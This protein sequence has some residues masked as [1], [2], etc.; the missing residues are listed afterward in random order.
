MRAE[1]DSFKQVIDRKDQELAWYRGRV[2]RLEEQLRGIVDPEL[3]QKQI[4][5][6]VN[7]QS[8]FGLADFQEQHPV[9]AEESKSAAAETP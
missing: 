4:H 7:D 8:Q 5:Q 3:D 6:V 1:R 2:T 9:E